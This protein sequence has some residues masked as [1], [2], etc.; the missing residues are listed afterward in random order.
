MEVSK[1]IKLNSGHEMPTIGLGTYTMFKDQADMLTVIP[2]AIDEGYRHIDTATVYGTET[3]IGEALEQMISSGKIR[4]E[5]IF[6]TCKVWNTCHQPDRAKASVEQ[7]LKDLKTEYIDMVLIHWPMAYAASDELVPKDENGDVMYA[8]IDYVDTWKALEECVEGGQV[9]SI[10]LS[11][12]NIEQITR[13]CDS[14]KI[15]PSNL[16]VELNAYLSNKKLADWCEEKGIVV[17]CYAPLSSPGRFWKESADLNLIED[18]VVVKIAEI[19]KK[20]AA[21]VALRFLLQKGYVALPK[22]ANP[23]RLAENIDV[24]DFNLSVDEMAELDSLN[25]DLRV[26]CEDYAKSSPYYPF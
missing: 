22:S 7:S 14:A 17:S 5:E 4:R 13:V 9:K 2:A 21:Q 18:E 19:H 15:Q 11:N 6:I 23:K 26:Y 24:Y 25:K 1:S 3:F 10:G 8:D 12:F 16:Q 20:T